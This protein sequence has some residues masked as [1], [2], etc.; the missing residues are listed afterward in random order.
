VQHLQGTGCASQVVRKGGG[1]SVKES[2]KQINSTVQL[3]WEGIANVGISQR[4]KGS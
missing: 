1:D 4:D 2:P 3:L